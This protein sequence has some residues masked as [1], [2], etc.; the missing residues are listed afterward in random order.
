MFAPI[1]PPVTVS[2]AS[3]RPMSA[4]TGPM[5][6]GGRTISI[7]LIPNLYIIYARIHPSRPVVTKAPCAYWNPWPAMIMLAGPMNAK[8][9]PRYAGAFPLVINM[10]SSVP[11]PFISSTVPGFIPN[12]IGTSTDAPN[13]AKVCC[14][15]NGTSILNGTFSST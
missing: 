7:H 12:S 4:T 3:S 5:A 11:I 2:P 8:L 15:L 10:K 6:A 9:D 1:A 14:R 13:I